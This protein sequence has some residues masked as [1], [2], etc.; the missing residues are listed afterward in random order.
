MNNRL[1]AFREL[2]KEIIRLIPRRQRD[3]AATKFREFERNYLRTTRPEPAI[4]FSSE[5]EKR[6]YLRRILNC[7]ETQAYFFEFDEQLFKTDDGCVEVIKKCREQI[8]SPQLRT[9]YL[10]GKAYSFLKQRKP[11][12][13]TL[14]FFL[15][16]IC[17]LQVSFSYMY[18]LIDFYQ[19][20]HRHPNYLNA[21]V[22]IRFFKKHLKTIK[23]L[24]E[25]DEDRDGEDHD[26]EDHN[27][28]DNFDGDN[29][30]EDYTGEEIPMSV[31]DTV[32]DL[33]VL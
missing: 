20:C 9:F 15:N 33:I 28:G 32:S 11:S 27:D 10:M 26:G 8:E 12:R 3:I 24:E 5:A 19:V 23:Q 22:P 6:Q 31:D 2:R 16:H 1:Q 13:Q 30:D 14:H 18:F 29:F 7:N 25:N 21:N 4:L 17:Q